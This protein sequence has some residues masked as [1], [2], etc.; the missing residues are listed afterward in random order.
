M[1][2]YIIYTSVEESSMAHAET[3]RP[4]RVRSRYDIALD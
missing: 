4:F 3:S 1:C 2:I